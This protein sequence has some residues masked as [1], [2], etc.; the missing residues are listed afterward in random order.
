MHGV[1]LGYAI[2]VDID[3]GA[4][5]SEYM[6]VFL[7][8]Q[9]HIAQKFQCPGWPFMS[10]VS[11][12]GLTL[13]HWCVGPTGRRTKPCP[14][15][16]DSSMH[17]LRMHCLCSK[18]YH[19]QLAEGIGSSSAQMTTTHPPKADHGKVDAITSKPTTGAGAI[20]VPLAA[21]RPSTRPGWS[22]RGVPPSGL[23]QLCRPG[24]N[25]T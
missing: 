15:L 2:V 18:L 9:L 12:R 6:R 17:G 22:S 20:S 4:R 24:T 3:K 8:K 11:T 25:T 19:T 14:R 10:T 7:H 16:N 1:L 23:R 5:S 13:P 21:L